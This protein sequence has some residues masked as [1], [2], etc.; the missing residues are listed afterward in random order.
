MSEKAT[1]KAAQTFA[2]AGQDRAA[3]AFAQLFGAKGEQK[4]GKR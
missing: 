4:K 1:E 3:A 2:F